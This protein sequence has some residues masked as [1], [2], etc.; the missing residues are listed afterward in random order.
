M[1]DESGAFVDSLQKYFFFANALNI[2][3][4]LSMVY[5]CSITFLSRL[6]ACLDTS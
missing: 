1:L 4:M 5:Q 2:L 6:G 3:D